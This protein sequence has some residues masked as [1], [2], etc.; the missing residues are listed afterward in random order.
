MHQCEMTLNML[1]RSRINP[2]M[3]AYTQLFGVFDYNWTPITPLG[4][5]AFIHK[6]IGQR[7]SHV[8]H[9]KVGYVIEPLP[10][11]YWHIYF[12]IPTTRGNRHTDTYVFIPSKFELPKNAAADRE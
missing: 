6:R 10:Q 9:G 1:H 4:T 2:K 5:K 11:Q 12:Y 8:D 3:S 7:R